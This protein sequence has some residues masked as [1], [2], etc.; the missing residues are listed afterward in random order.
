[1]TDREVAGTE[2][3]MPVEL[4]FRVIHHGG[5]YPNYYWKTRPVR[6]GGVENG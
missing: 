6:Q 3:G 5:G 2:I 1:M 4:T